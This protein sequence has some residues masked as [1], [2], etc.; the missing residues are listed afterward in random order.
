MKLV[1]FFSCAARLTRDM[2]DSVERAKG[3]NTRAIPT[4]AASGFQPLVN[5]RIQ[6]SC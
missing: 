2:F 3:M 5:R 6:R 1:Y 4:E